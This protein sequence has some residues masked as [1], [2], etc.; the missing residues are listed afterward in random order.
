MGSTAACFRGVWEAPRVPLGEHKWGA[1]CFRSCAA[2]VAYADC[3]MVVMA[4]FCQEL[5]VVSRK[6]EMGLH[7]LP[8]P[9]GLKLACP[10]AHETV[11]AL[12]LLPL[13]GR[14]LSPV[15]GLVLFPFN[16]KEI[17]M[18]WAKAWGYDYSRSCG[19][20]YA[21]KPKYNVLQG[22]LW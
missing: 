16:P 2:R 6:W 14:N 21:K 10:I 12:W 5:V 9:E 18:Q 19:K 8:L 20:Y 4:T 3:Q 7:L 13:R 11:A 22:W 1:P 17:K 15:F